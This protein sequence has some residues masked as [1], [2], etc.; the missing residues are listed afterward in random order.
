MNYENGIVLATRGK[1]KIILSNEY[2]YL[3]FYF[4][5]K[6]FRPQEVKSI[7]DLNTIKSRSIN[8]GYELD[9]DT[10]QWCLNNFEIL[11]YLD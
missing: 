1:S 3:G 6:C 2:G 11:G 10:F 8:H 7:H 5:Y 9:W 4:G